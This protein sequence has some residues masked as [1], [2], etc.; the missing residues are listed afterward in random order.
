MRAISASGLIGPSADSERESDAFYARIH[1]G[2][3]KIAAREP[4]RVC[5]IA[6]DDGDNSIDAIELRIRAL[7]E[8]RLEQR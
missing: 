3:E 6:N 8:E 1:A 4:H 7:V 2:Y 5:T